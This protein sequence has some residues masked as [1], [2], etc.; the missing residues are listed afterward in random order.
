V[1]MKS[2]CSLRAAAS[3]PPTGTKMAV[4]VSGRF[5]QRVRVRVKVRVRVRVRVMVRVGSCS[6]RDA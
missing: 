3:L 6:G 5:L 4:M 1:A 2:A